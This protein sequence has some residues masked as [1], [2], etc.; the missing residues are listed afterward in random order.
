M[1]PKIYLRDS[2]G[3]LYPHR[4]FSRHIIA[5]VLMLALSL[6]VYSCQSEEIPEPPSRP[7]EELLSIS[8][9]DAPCWLGIQPGLTT[10]MEAMSLI[11]DSLL[12]ISSSNEVRLEDDASLAN[13][14]IAESTHETILLTL[15]LE[16][17]GSVSI[18]SVDELVTWLQL[19]HVSGSLEL[20]IE[21]YG[22]PTFIYVYVPPAGLICYIVDLYY[23]DL[24]IKIAARECLR[25]DDEGPTKMTST[26]GGGF[27]LIHPEMQV[28][29]VAFTTPNASFPDFLTGSVGVSNERLQEI[30]SQGTPW[31]GYDYY[32]TAD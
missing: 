14:S 6:S 11:S 29:S 20:L 18:R 13:S 7:V 26:G 8:K 32:R 2:N 5:F 27:A 3:S 31:L 23:P 4:I 21:R 30:T 19:S 17:E 12:E 1:L 15:R 10:R 24:G 25:V 16:E 28:I 9:C 22:P